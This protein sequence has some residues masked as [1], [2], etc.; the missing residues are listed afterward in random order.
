MEDDPSVRDMPRPQGR[1][2]LSGLALPQRKLWLE[3]GSRCPVLTCNRPGKAR[4][5]QPP[6]APV[7]KRLLVW[8]V[9]GKNFQTCHSWVSLTIGRPQE[10]VTARAMGDLPDHITQSSPQAN[11]TLFSGCI[12][13]PEPT[14]LCLAVL[15]TDASVGMTSNRDL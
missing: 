1:G 3:V 5:D 12:N 7:P 8:P 14:P 15:A 2:A 11:C 9:A 4:F 10:V 6:C 13:G